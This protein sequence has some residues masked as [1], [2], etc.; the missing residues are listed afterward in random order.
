MEKLALQPPAPSP[1]LLRVDVYHELRED[2]LACRLAPGAELREAE[3][4]E[5]FAVSKSPVRDALSRLVHEGLVHVIPRQGYRVAP[6]SLKDV[7]DMCEYRAVLESAC[8]RAAAGNA[9][10]AQLRALDRFRAFDPAH[11][12]GFL[13]YNREF[14]S[15]LAALCP[16]ARLVSAVSAQMEQMDRVVTVSLG[17]MR[18]ADPARL[19]AQHA[20]VIDALQQRDGRRAA[21]LIARHIAAAQKRVCA[22]LE[23]LAVVE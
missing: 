2:I 21:A 4:A 10:D 16:N 9:T 7:R 6:I 18:Q 5:R 15:A 3:L 12:D 20:E 22:A 19:V 1:R 8:L 13:G 11:P 14:H 17:A 23:R